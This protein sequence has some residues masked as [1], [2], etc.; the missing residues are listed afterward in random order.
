M[1]ISLGQIRNSSRRGS[2]PYLFGWMGRPSVT[3]MPNYH[4]TPRIL[5]F[6]KYLPITRLV[7]GQEPSMGTENL[8][9]PTVEP[10]STAQHQSGLGLIP[11]TIIDTI[12]QS[13]TMPAWLWALI[14]SDR[15]STEYSACSVLSPC[16]LTQDQDQSILPQKQEGPPG[17]RS[18]LTDLENREYL[19]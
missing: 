5:S 2:E 19:G 12:T 18:W 17:S 13:R 1:S 15:S 9:C 4:G 10:E 16:Q 6:L 3:G 7:F 8:N 11:N 14:N